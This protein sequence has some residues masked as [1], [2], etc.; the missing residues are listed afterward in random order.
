MGASGDAFGIYTVSAHRITFALLDHTQCFGGT[1]SADWSL[2]LAGLS[3]TSRTRNSPSRTRP[4]SKQ[5]GR[6]Q[7]VA[8][9]PREVPAGPF[10]T[11]SRWW[12][13]SVTLFAPDAADESPP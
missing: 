2:G 4:H 3:L 9:T 1:W 12:R 13:A 10:R 8:G 5:C 6:S 7:E 11:T